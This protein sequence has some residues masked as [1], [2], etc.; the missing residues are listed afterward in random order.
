M[1]KSTTLGP[2]PEVQGPNIVDV[3][4]VLSGS[5]L[6]KYQAGPKIYCISPKVVDVYEIGN[7]EI[8]HD[9]YRQFWDP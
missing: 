2:G 3:R 8:D 1:P 5:I 7:S 6:Q 9:E 4:M